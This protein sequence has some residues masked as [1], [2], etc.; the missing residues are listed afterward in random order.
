MRV[1]GATIAVT[2]ATGFLGTHISRA[3]LAAGATVVG[4]VRSPEKGMHLA[5]D[6]VR[7]RRADLNDVAALTEAFA[8]CDA[9]VA[10]AALA[11]KGG[12]SYGA[13][14]AA[15][16]DGVRRTFAAIEGAKVPRVLHISSVGVYQVRAGRVMTEDT[17]LR[18]RF[19]I[20]PSLLTT[21]WRYKLTKA[22]GERVAWA[23]ARALGCGL[24]VFRPGPVYG[25]GDVKLMPKLVQRAQRRT[26]WVPNVG[27]PMV[28]AGDI[29]RGVVAAFEE[30]TALGQAYNFGG[31]THPLP[32]VIRTLAQ[33]MHTTCTV[34]SV[35]L[36]L[37]VRF[38]DTKAARDLGLKH[39]SLLDGFVEAL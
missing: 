27:L 17:P 37:G 1:R 14:R 32:D 7:F 12:A 28:H 9:V 39:R 5:K 19:R 18:T 33:A 6:G 2:G 22:E 4:V 24:T 16:V 21:N 11:V 29:A 35:P 36:G 31:V 3:L 8:G 13:F 25:S 10:N 30:E 34:R 15:N 23:E 20:D 38:D 26:V